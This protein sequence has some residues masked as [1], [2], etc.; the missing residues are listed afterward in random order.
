MIPQARLVELIKNLPA[1][2]LELLDLTW[3][4]TGEDG[5]LDPQKISFHYT[6]MEKAIAEAESYS[7]ATKEMVQCLTQLLH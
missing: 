4:L 6:E 7:R 5:A 3:Q 2:N 1:V